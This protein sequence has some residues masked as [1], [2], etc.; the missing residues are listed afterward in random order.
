[1]LSQERLYGTQV[2]FIKYLHSV[3]T[4]VVMCS[5]TTTLHIMTLHVLF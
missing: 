1:L 2:P 3:H 4:Y 5:I